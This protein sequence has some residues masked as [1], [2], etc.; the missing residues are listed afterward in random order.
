M[1]SPLI[2]AFSI[3]AVGLRLLS[4]VLRVHAAAATGSVDFINPNSNGGS[5]L[6]NGELYFVQVVF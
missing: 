1:L 6:D 2:G 3:A 5:M 4:T